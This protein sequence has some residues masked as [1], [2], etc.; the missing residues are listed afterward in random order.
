MHICTF[1]YACLC[2]C[3]CVCACLCVRVF[4]YVRCVRVN[5]T[6]VPRDLSNLDAGYTGL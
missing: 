2:V 4:V 3:I 1:V 5:E 6:N